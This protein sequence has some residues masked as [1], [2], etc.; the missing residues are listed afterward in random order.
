MSAAPR[1]SEAAAQRQTEQP[2]L[3][4]TMSTQP[5]SIF[6]AYRGAGRLRGRV[7]LITGGDSGIG[8]AVALHFAREA[9]E[10]VVIVH[11]PEEH[12]DARET[13]RLIQEESGSG[14]AKTQCLLLAN[15]VADPDQCAD[16]CRRVADT[17]GRIHILVN[18]AAVQFECG[19]PEQFQVAQITRTFQVNILSHFWMTQ[20]AV[21]HMPTDG[22][23]CIINTTSVTAYNG[24]PALLPYS[25]TKGAIVSFTRSL[26]LA[27][28]PRNIRVNA[29]APGPVWT[30]LIVASFSPEQLRDFA[31]AENVAMHQVAQ[32]ANIAPS[33]VFL[34]SHDAAFMTGQVLHPNGGTIVNA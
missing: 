16:I 11:L 19:Q 14:G 20:H 15:D 13:Q 34:A 3:Q 30:P 33:Y 26:A 9:A 22:S 24:H 7:A 32:P 18:N 23:A 31:K 1:S 5:I 17:F 25:A 8:R 4:H 10:A 29:V 28:A 6:D 12:T 27:L 2:G 21:Q